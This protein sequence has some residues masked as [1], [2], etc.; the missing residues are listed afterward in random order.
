MAPQLKVER[1]DW[2]RR[3]VLPA[4]APIAD[5]GFEEGVCRC[6]EVEAAVRRWEADE[7]DAILVICFDLRARPDR[8]AGAAPDTSADQDLANVLLRSGVP[9]EYVTSH[10]RDAGPVVVAA[11]WPAAAG[12]A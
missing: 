10:V 2:V 5:A 3:S 7:V 1:E 11:R 4:R 6:Q 8:P 12:C 9:F